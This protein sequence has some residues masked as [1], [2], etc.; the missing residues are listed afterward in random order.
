MKTFTTT[1]PGFAISLAS[2]CAV[3]T[4]GL[5]KTVDRACP[6]HVT[7]DAGVKLEPFTVNVKPGCPAVIEL[8]ASDVT[9][10]TG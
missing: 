7:D 2:I 6:F 1:K 3:S 9:P 5:W 10:G 4:V 8:G